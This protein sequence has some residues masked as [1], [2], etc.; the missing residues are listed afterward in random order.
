MRENIS[1]VI[2]A[3]AFV[4]AN[5]QF[6]LPMTRSLIPSLSQT[7]HQFGIS[8]R[9]IRER[10]RDGKEELPFQ[11]FREGGRGRGD[12]HDRH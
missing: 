3:P 1:Q 5:N 10:L 8:L 7:Y 9:K 12:P 6:F 2:V 11:L 4:L